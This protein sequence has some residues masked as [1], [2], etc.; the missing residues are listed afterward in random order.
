MRFIDY[1]KILTESMTF[2]V[3]STDH[4]YQSIGEIAYKMNDYAF[5]IKKNDPNGEK[6]GY[7]VVVADGEGYFEKEGTLNIYQF[8]L[9]D[10]TFKKIVSAVKYY[11]GEYG[12]TIQGPVTFDVSRLYNCNTC[13]LRVNMET[14]KKVPPSFNLSNM[15]AHNILY[16]VLNYP[17]DDA[18]SLNAKELLMKIEQ[19]ED[20]S[21]HL[22]KS[23]RAEERDGN[24][25]TFGQSKERIEE[26]LRELKKMCEWAIENNYTNISVS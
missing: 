10:E 7:E 9:T 12:V 6:T 11:L 24:V 20:N 1:Y 2:S 26:I 17:E 18:H 8:Q 22:K 25:T 19:I 16:N 15:N 5:S 4:V 13:R 21:F 3:Q 14:P 23:S